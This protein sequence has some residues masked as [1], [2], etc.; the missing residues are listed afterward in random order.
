MGSIEDPELVVGGV[1]M[2]LGSVTLIAT[3]A[4]INIPL[5]GLVLATLLLA[6]GTLLVGL[7]IGLFGG[8]KT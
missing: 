7:D 1:L 8:E 5:T 6:G 3:A 2:L 4:G